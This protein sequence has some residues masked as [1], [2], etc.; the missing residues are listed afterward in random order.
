MEIEDRNPKNTEAIMKT[1]IFL[2]VLVIGFF[3]CTSPQSDQV[4]QQEKEQIQKEVKVTLDSIFANWGRLDVEGALQYYSP[5]LVVLSDTTIMDYQASKKAWTDFFGSAAT[6]K[7]TEFNLEFLVVTRDVVISTWVGKMDLVFKSGDK[8]R[9]DPVGATYDFK[10]SGGQWK[11][12]YEHASGVPE[13]EKAV[14]K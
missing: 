4:T 8:L 13:M 10:K 7:W 12:V 9:M 1:G 5:D 14:Q 2:S 6:A 11:A 3:G